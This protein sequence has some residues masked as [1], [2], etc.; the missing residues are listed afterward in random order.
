MA[1]L[2][3]LTREAA[4]IAY[5]AVSNGAEIV[6]IREQDLNQSPYGWN[7]TKRR[8]F[9][10][11]LGLPVPEGT[12]GTRSD[13]ELFYLSGIDDQNPDV[14]TVLRSPDQPV[15]TEG[16]GKKAQPQ[17][18]SLAEALGAPER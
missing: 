7:S 14:I 15:E 12:W 3:L 1:E 4:R 17:Q 13:I 8:A 18:E 2:T 10:I 6:T 11:A 9:I 5:L 16:E